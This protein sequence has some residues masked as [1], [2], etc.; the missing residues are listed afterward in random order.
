MRKVNRMVQI[1][2]ILYDIYGRVKPLY[3]LFHLLV[4]LS[5]MYGSKI[6][7][8]RFTVYSCIIRIRWLYSRIWFVS[9][10]ISWPDES[11]LCH[12][13]RLTCRKGRHWKWSFAFCQ[14]IICKIWRLVS[15]EKTI[16][17][18]KIRIIKTYRNAGMRCTY[19][20]ILKWTSSVHDQ[21]QM[22]NFHT[23]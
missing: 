7:I 19:C 1:T 8:L 4:Q 3:L 18:K 22:M 2:C 16:F 17:G 5:R 11:A 15:K 20:F 6:E 23:F 13:R 10:V 12:S 14:S 9:F 21:N